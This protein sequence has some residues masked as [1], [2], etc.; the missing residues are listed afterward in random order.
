MVAAAVRQSG[1]SL[2]FASQDLRDDR[3]LVLEALQT[4][5]WLFPLIS[6]RLQADKEVVRLAVH[7]DKRLL[8]FASAELRSDPEFIGTGNQ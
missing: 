2:R 3:D 8:R 5:S 7:R 1:S 6:K 4:A